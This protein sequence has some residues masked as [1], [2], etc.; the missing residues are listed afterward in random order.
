M[1]SKRHHYS[2]L[3]IDIEK[4][5]RRSDPVQQWL[6]ERLYELTEQSLEEIGVDPAADPL[7]QDRG[8]GFF[9]LFP[10]TVPKTDLAGHFVAT[11][12]RK[13]L[14]YARTSSDEAVLR[15]RVALHAG[16]VAWDG[17]G[18]V[19]TDLNVAC[20][21][22]DL[23]PLRAAL[24]AGRRSGLAL[25]VSDQWYRS[26]IRHGYPEVDRPSFRPVRFDAKEI[27]NET[28][29][30]RVPGYHAPPGIGDWEPR[31]ALPHP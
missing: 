14:G 29:W 16:E 23:A 30:V 8:D 13:L 2:I 9:W 19:G 3:V 31:E 6:R 5:G 22:V 11:L 20:R 7:P 1:K 25:S 15:L 18:W 4:F 27:V 28:A 17:K 24:A 12:W 21:L 26:V 10:G